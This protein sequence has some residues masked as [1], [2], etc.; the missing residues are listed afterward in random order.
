V[1]INC[2]NLFDAASGFGGYRESGF[3]REGGREGMW[4]YLQ[5]AWHVE[6]QA[7]AVAKPRG[8]KRAKA[9]AP[10]PARS[11]LPAIDRT[12]KL[13]IGGVQARPDQ[14]YSRPITSPDGTLRGEVAE[15]NRKDIRNAVEAAHA[16]SGW[17]RASG[18]A[19]S[20][21]LYYIAEN[22]APRAE[23]F[24]ERIAA[25]T[26]G[27]V[28]TGRREVDAT[29]AR[30]FTCAAWADK[31]DGA[32]HQVPIRGVTLAMNEPLGVIGIA[33]PET[34]PLL[35]FASL[36][37]AA[38]AL[39]NAVVAMPSEAHPLAVTELYT[40]LDASD[41]P[42]GVINIVTGAKDALAKVLA[43]HD[44]V[45][46]VWYFGHQAAGAEIE[47]ASAGNMKRTWVEWHPR[48]WMDPRQ[49]EGRELLRQATQVKNIWIPYGE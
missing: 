25:M 31:Y 39:G 26:G 24:A 37:G 5:P 8:P 14:G 47:R 43:E 40:V 35:G 16:A 6:P 19:R 45:D 17:A 48:D 12:Y 33:C 29:I 9:P 1:W 42:P 44:D 2:T 30:L 27:D 32:V 34:Y 23:E 7:G 22:L 3:G 11:S 41:V 38:T 4:E 21:V 13:F 46:A 18:H 20:Q 10:T 36:V 49:A 15:G 28:D